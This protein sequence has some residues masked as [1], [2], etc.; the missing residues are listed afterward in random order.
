MWGDFDGVFQGET[1]FGLNGATGHTI[2]QRKPTDG[3]P[4]AS[5]IKLSMTGVSSFGFSLTSARECGKNGVSGDL[6]VVSRIVS[7]GSMST[8]KMDSVAGVP[9]EAS[10]LPESAPPA[11]E[12]EES[13]PQ[14]RAMLVPERGRI[15][16][17]SDK[18]EAFISRLSTRDNFWHRICSLIWLPYAFFSGIKMKAIEA[19]SFAAVL[20]FRRFNRNWYHAMAGGALLANSEIAGGMYVFGICGGD[21]TVVCKQLNYTFLRPCFGPAVYKITPRENLKELMATKS[22]FNILLDLDISQQVTL[23][24]ER[25]KRIG[26]CEAT[27]HVT[28]KWQHKA[29]KAR[30]ANLPQVN[31]DKEGV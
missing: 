21:Y 4:W 24:V 8:L 2:F 1:Q 31:S 7:S 14:R 29:R 11:H 3:P 30:R 5:Y 22:E 6:E 15:A 28:P 12:A 13:R 25:D 18:F 27:F 10:G 26:K 23:P 19:N 20:P 17:W 9:D 16:R